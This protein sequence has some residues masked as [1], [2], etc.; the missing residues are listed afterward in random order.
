MKNFLTAFIVISGITFFTACKK[1]NSALAPQS[2]K[3]ATQKVKQPSAPTRVKTEFS[4]FGTKAYTYNADFN[5]L[6]YTSTNSTV[7]TYPD[8]LHII[9]TPSTGYETHYDLNKKGLIEKA[10]TPYST[11]YFTYNSKKQLTEI[12]SVGN[13]GDINALKYVYNSSGNLDT[14]T[15]ISN[16]KV[17]V[18][19][20]YTYYEDQPNVMDND[21]IGEGFRGVSSKNLL[22]TS[23]MHDGSLFITDFS[24]AFDPFGRVVKISS[25]VNGSAQPDFVYTYY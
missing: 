7:Y 20:T 1:D 22:K 2:E 16:G 5:S 19:T 3:L 18:F 25:T 15:S 9:E 12:L 6:G 10:T 14:L 13:S 8:A 21:V 11:Q 4:S 23:V 17:S 24:Y